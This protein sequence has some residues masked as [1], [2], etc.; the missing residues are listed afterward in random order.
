MFNY[1]SI[2]L[3]GNLQCQSIVIS[4]AE[5]NGGTV[6]IAC[7]EDYGI[8]IN[9]IRRSH[10]FIRHTYEIAELQRFGGY[11]YQVV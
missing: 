11:N 2:Y 7:G 1:M 10:I 8:F 4:N 5:W 9:G 3:L 6:R